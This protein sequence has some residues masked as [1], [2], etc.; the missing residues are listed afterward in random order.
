M[1]VFLFVLFTLNTVLVTGQGQQSVE[2]Y[3]VLIQKVNIY[4]E[5]HLLEHKDYCIAEDEEHNILFLN[6]K[7]GM[8]HLRKFKGNEQFESPSEEKYIDIKEQ[9]HEYAINGDV[10]LIGGENFIFLT[11]KEYS[12]TDP[13]CLYLG[14]SDF[15]A[16]R[17]PAN[18]QFNLHVNVYEVAIS[19][20]GKTAAGLMV[21][22]YGY[23]TNKK[24]FERMV[25]LILIDV[26]KG[27]YRIDPLGYN[28]KK[29]EQDH[30]HTKEFGSEKDII[31]VDRQ[32]GLQHCAALNK[33]K[34]EMEF[35]DN[36]HLLF[37][38]NKY[39]EDATN[40]IVNTQKA[41]VSGITSSSKKELTIEGEQFRTFAIEGKQVYY[42]SYEAKYISFNHPDNRN[43]IHLRKYTWNGSSLIENKEKM[44]FKDTLIQKGNFSYLNNLS[45]KDDKLILL[46]RRQ[47][48]RKF[49]RFKEHAIILGFN[50]NDLS[51]Q[52]QA[53]AYDNP[54]HSPDS[55]SHENSWFLGGTVTSIAY[56]KGN[57]LLVCYRP[58][59]TGYAIMAF[60]VLKAFKK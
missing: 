52:L 20:D 32:S 18:A 57:K 11:N 50:K 49:E 54:K 8:L 43:H 35:I 46:A 17:N 12:F 56:N 27:T 37:S 40:A 14:A 26:E 25:H 31:D 5:Q 23:N 10:H 42:V 58:K 59:Y 22:N 30:T 39:L 6:E 2:R 15:D 7:S 48:W 47:N 44:F 24:V 34:L 55:G 51:L 13:K 28:L 19:P 1:R 36:Q 21:T 60:D 33:A 41:M 3:P 4:E 16:Y 38:F 53:E 9:P 45:V 29:T